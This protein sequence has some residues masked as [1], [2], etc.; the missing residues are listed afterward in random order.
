M[1]DE[2]ENQNHTRCGSPLMEFPGLW[3]RL[4]VELESKGNNG[5]FGL[6]EGGDALTLT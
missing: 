6:Y 3:R 5:H 2:T 1:W 4:V